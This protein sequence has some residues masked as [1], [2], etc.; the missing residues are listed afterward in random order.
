MSDQSVD[1]SQVRGGLP[2]ILHDQ[3]SSDLIG[4]RIRDDDC[5]GLIRLIDSLLHEAVSAWLETEG[6]SEAEVAE[7][8]NRSLIPS[9]RRIGQ[10]CLEAIRFHSLTVYREGIEGLGR[11]YDLARLRNLGLRRGDPELSWSAPS[12]AAFTEL[13]VIGSYATFRHRFAYLPPLLN[14]RVDLP[15]AS[16]RASPT[17]MTHPHSDRRWE[18]RLRAHLDAASS[19]VKDDE[20]LFSLFFHD[21]EHFINSLCQF[22]LIVT[23]AVH[24]RGERIFCPNFCRYYRYR[25][26]PV[27]ER[28]V[29]PATLSELFGS[30]EPERLASFLRGINTMCARRLRMA[31]AWERGTQWSDPIR[32]FLASFPHEEA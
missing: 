11:I 31:N 8:R 12:Q 3:E 18:D 6:G 2:N 32:E 13:Y 28:L 30:A 5:V 16:S 14:E 25:I 27:A 23:Y 22:D 1:L 4:Q 7:S 21:E 19:L 17:L 24:R 20:H 26:M 29:A 9:I 15:D 10:V